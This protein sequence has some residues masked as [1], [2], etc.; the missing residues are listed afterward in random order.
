MS[1]VKL[2]RLLSLL[3]VLLLAT[4]AAA[5]FPQAP[6]NPGC[7]PAGCPA[8]GEMVVARVDYGIRA[9]LDALA[10][11]L[12]IWEVH[13]AEGWLLAQIPYSSVADLQAQG[14]TVAVDWE[15]TAALHQPNLPLAGQTQGIPS[16]P[17]YRTVAE[18]PLLPL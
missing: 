6:A 2:Y 10:P 3:A 18:L 7:P 4:M 8:P 11:A 16:S 1:G 12:D 13:A 14:Y 5:P 15:Q 17:C 9:R